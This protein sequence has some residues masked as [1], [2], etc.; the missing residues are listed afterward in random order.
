MCA[1]KHIA[2]HHII[3]RNGCAMNMD[4]T[5]LKVNVCRC[6]CGR[7]TNTHPREENKDKRIGMFVHGK[8]ILGLS[9]SSFLKTDPLQ[10]YE[11]KATFR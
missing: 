4:T 11:K 10:L 5:L 2:V 1:V 6:Q 9:V 8:S 3:I 7:F